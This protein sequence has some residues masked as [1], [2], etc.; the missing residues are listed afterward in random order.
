MELLLETK[1]YKVKGIEY[2]RIH[3]PKRVSKNL[4]LQEGDKV[5]VEFKEIRRPE[6]QPIVLNQT[7]L[8]EDNN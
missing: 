8:S 5:L 1:C 7:K 6:Y 3:L 2:Y 4:G